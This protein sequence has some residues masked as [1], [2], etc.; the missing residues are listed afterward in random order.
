MQEECLWFCFH[1]LLQC[2]LDEVKLHWNTHYIRQSSHTTVPGRPHELYNLPEWF[3]V[4]DCLTSVTTEDV[5]YASQHFLQAGEAEANQSHYQEYF[6]YV[7]EVNNLQTPVNWRQAL[8][9]Y[10]QLQQFANNGA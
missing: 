4:E 6:S 10:H 5:D 7:C 8:N 9:L 1:Q 2:D 3:G